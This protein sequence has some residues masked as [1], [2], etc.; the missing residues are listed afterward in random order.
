M[1]AVIMAGGAGTRLWPLS[2]QK[3]PKQ[4]QN[5]ITDKSLIRETFDRIK[6]KIE[7]KKIFISTTPE[8]LDDIKAQIPELKDKNFIIEP[9]LMGNAASNCL[10]SF[11]LHKLDPKAAAIFL[12]SDHV[13]HDK[14]KFLETLEFAEELIKKHSKKILTIGINPTRPDTGLGY[15]QMGEQVGR[16]ASM[17]VFEVKKFVE[18]PDLKTAEAYLASWEFL[19]NSGMF[20]WRTDHILSLYKKHMPKTYMAIEKIVQAIGTEKEWDILQKEY[21]NVEVN[22]IDYAIIEK[23]KDILVVPGNFPWSDVGSWG[24]LLDSLSEVYKTTIITKGHHVG[25]DSTECLVIAGE[26]LVATVGLKNI[27]VVDTPDALLVCDRNQS[28]KVKDLLAKL[29]V[30]GKHQYL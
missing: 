6:T 11:I 17:R 7:P 1:Y 3:K 29:K 28:G 10:A 22:S 25:I 27:I 9:F 12:P 5:L 2:R 8:Y 18:K 14:R 24:S 30:D 4:L 26:K 23:T 19:W 21:A 16:K 15:I 20:V 13:I